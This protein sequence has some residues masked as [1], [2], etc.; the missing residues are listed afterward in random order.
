MRRICTLRGKKIVYDFDNFLEVALAECCRALID[1]S[2]DLPV[3][4]RRGL[5]GFPL[6]T[7]P[8]HAGEDLLN[9]RQFNYGPFNPL[10]KGR[11][12]RCLCN[13]LAGHL[14]QFVAGV[15]RGHKV[16]QVSH[17]ARLVAFA[18]QFVVDAV[19]AFCR[20]VPPLPAASFHDDHA[21]G[22][23]PSE[24]GRYHSDLHAST[25][26]NFAGTRRLPKVDHSEIDAALG[27][28]ETLQMGAEILGV[29]VDQH[30]QL[31]HQLAQGT[32]P[33]ELGD[34]DQEAG[35]AAGQDLQ[36]PN[37]ARAH[38]VAADHLPQASALLGI[39]PFQTDYS[40][41]LEER[42]FHIV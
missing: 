42:L 15:E 4:E 17:D 8:S 13:Q 37:R 25:R 5:F 30:D 28:C 34:N 3:V 41:Q 11:R 20:R 2:L 7:C 21:S 32:V 14:C 12:L 18:P 35:I 31:F 6:N 24:Q 10:A 40:E 27:L 26:C 33:C 36:R 19:E 22:D 1:K 39:Q 9:L 16:N 38:R 29:I 23:E